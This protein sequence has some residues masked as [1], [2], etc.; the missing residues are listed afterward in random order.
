MTLHVVAAIDESHAGDQAVRTAVEITNR[1]LGKVTPL[2]V[3]AAPVRRGIR[4]VVAAGVAEV[5]EDTSSE[6]RVRLQLEHD[7]SPALQLKVAYGVPSIEIC[8]FA[9][10]C[11]ADLIVVGRKEHCERSRLLLGDTGD[12]VARRSRI[13]TLFVPATGSRL[14]KVLLALDGSE[15]GMRVLEQACSFVRAI[16]ASLHVITVESAMGES[17]HTDLPLTRSA[18]IRAR[19][20]EV[21]ARENLPD[22]PVTIRRGRVADEVLKEI[23][24]GDDDVLVIGHHRGGPAWLVQTCSTA[25]Q[26][27]HAAPCAVLTIPL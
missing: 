5:E 19:V 22:A 24:A 15:R 12:A 3:V 7:S 4:R 9:E 2:H 23:E 8:R 20:Q 25:Q 16:G 11:H 27:G 14:A 13:P 21:L 1:S 26:L 10:E 17:G 6:N 18:R